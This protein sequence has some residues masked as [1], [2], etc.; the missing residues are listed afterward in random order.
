[1]KK[2]KIKSNDNEQDDELNLKPSMPKKIIDRFED[3][4]SDW[5]KII[6]DLALEGE[7]DAGL[8]TALALT[9]R[10]HETLFK[11]ST[12]Y[13]EWFDYCH[14]VSLNWWF[15]FAKKVCTRKDYNGATFNMVM[16]NRAGWG[17]QTKNSDKPPDETP[18]SEPSKTLDDFKPQ[19]TISEITKN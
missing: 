11:Y 18:T 15:T 8:Y 6:F 4:A 5:K 14:D 7:A 3:L 17:Q 2:E 19:S 12:E 10:K 16:Q 1:M 13:A 9:R